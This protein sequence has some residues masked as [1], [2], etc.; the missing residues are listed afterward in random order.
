MHN[1][2]RSS[3]RHRFIDVAVFILTF[4]QISKLV[5]RKIIQYLNGKN[6]I[7]ILPVLETL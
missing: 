3:G 5:Q 1:V 6:R 7:M 4:I 2:H